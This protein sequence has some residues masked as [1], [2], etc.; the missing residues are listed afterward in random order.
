MTATRPSPQW[1]EYVNPETKG[2]LELHANSLVDRSAGRSYPIVNQIPRFVE[3]DKYVEAFGW[4]WNRFPKTQ[5]DSH[6]GLP[7]SGDRLRTCLGE[8]LWNNLSGKHVL[9]CGCGAGRFTEILLQRGAFLTSVDLSTAVDANAK[10]FP[11][12]KSHRIAKADIMS[13]PFAPQ[14]FDVVVCV[15][16]IQHTPNS[17]ETIA[18]LYEQVR[19]GGWLVIDH[20][21]HENGRWSSIKPLIRMWLKRQKPEKTLPF[22]ESMVEKFLPWHQRFRS[23]YP[24][25]FLLCRIS[26]IVTYLRMI[27]ELSD[28]LQ[29]EWAILDTH[30]SLTDWFKHLRTQPQIQSTLD[31]LGLKSIWCALGG[32]GVE[33][34]GQRPV[35]TGR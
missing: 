27:P 8:E 22:V 30:D 3:N 33:A 11:V 26:P 9:E 15:G 16:V 10:N 34:R 5:L 23:N 12:D 25:W 32:N 1:P 35:A 2:V 24:L 31:K 21:T 7:I 14:Q 28:P 6:T 19:P 4:Q 20:Y 29:K 17:E 18:A 13:L